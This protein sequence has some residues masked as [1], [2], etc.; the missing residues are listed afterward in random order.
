MEQNNGK[1]ERVVAPEGFAGGVICVDKPAGCSSHDVVYRIRRLFGTAQVGHTG[2]LDPMATGA[3]VLMVGRAVKASEYLTA[4]N[5]EYIATLRLGI[6]TDTEDTEG[7]V[8]SC[9]CGELPRI[10]AVRE[11]AERMVGSIMQTPPMYS[12]LKVNG[13]KLVDLARRGVEIERA[14][15]PVEIYS[16]DVEQAEQADEFRLRVKCSKGTYI[17][18]LCAD[19]GKLLGCG[20]AMSSLRRVASGDFSLEN[21]YTLE[22][23]EEMS[24]NGRYLALCPVERLF[25]SLPEVRLSEFF[26]RLGRCG[27]ELYQKKLRTAFPSGQRVRLCDADGGFFALAEAR[28]FPEGS[29]LKPIKQFR[30]S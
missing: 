26:A 23:L 16:I 21:A 12:A 7:A 5:K 14:A 18:T 3:L 6:T 19:I 27:C 4:E 1:R 17:R 22:G 24:V 29:A 30:T 25:D 9:F 8:L 2:T 10:D 13:K 28:D 20:A 15:R 11:A